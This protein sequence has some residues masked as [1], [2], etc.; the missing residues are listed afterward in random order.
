MKQGTRFRAAL[1]AVTIM[2]LAIAMLAPAA[3][4]AKGNGNGQGQGQAKAHGQAKGHGHGNGQAR[5]NGHAKGHANGSGEGHGNGQAKGHGQTDADEQTDDADTSTEAPEGA[6]ATGDGQGKGGVNHDAM[7]AC[8]NGGWSELQREDGTRFSNQGRCVSYAVHGGVVV[9]VVPTVTITFVASAETADACDATGTLVD[10]GPATSY[11][12]TLQV[13]A[14][15]GALLAI[16]TDALG[17][18]SV[19]LGTFTSLQTLDLTVDGV[20]SG[21]VIVDCTE[22]PEVPIV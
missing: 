9:P 4:A 11:V 20:T 12:G 7:A 14:V 8:K 21:D 22:V 3:G 19:P 16:T 18:S 5:G 17:D 10:F 6:E 1:A 15:A 2:L 13:D